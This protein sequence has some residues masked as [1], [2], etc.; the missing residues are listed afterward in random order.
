MVPMTPTT[1]LRRLTAVA[2]LTL[3]AFGACGSDSDGDSSADNSD[4]SSSSKSTEGGEEAAGGAA[5]EGD[6]VDIVD[7]NYAP[8]NLKVK[9]GTEVTFTNKDDF[10]HTVTA[11]DKSFDSKNMDKDAVFKHTFEKA[12]TFDY[13][14]AIHNSMTGKVTVE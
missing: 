12:G 4:A 2:V 13:I 7:F 10:A 3:F 9:V 8:P 5:T 6:S 1:R 11:N 14:C